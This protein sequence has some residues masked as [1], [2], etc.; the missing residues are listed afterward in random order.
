[1]RILLTNDDGIE[2][3]GIATLYRAVQSYGDVQVVAPSKVRSA[4]GHAVTFHRP[5]EAWP[6]VM[7]DAEGREVAEGMAL[8]GMPADCVKVGLT[9]FV[10]EPVDLVLSGI[11]AGCNVGVHTLYSG[12]VAAAREAAIMGVPAIAVSLFLDRRGD[13]I[14]WD[15]AE[16]AAGAVL[17]RLLDEPFPPGTFLNVNL[18][19]LDEAKE[20]KGICVA[21]ANLSA[22]TDHYTGEADD[23]G[24]YE[25][26]VGQQVSFGAVTEG[27]DAERL[28]AGYTTVTPLRFDPNDLSSI[29]LWRS[30]LLG[31][32]S[33]G[34]ACD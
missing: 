6:Q 27:T 14:R 16:R 29:D 33:K 7:K 24:R 34:D 11:N 15:R 13:S 20:P 19:I 2:A 28:F 23:A 4:C 25:L 32:G 5:L 17:E 9:R 8:Y 31:D 30:R 18:P 1:M 10:E 26:K 3:P 12:T 22:M 21:P